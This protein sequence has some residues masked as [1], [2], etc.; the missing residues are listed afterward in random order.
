M[1]EIT[2]IEAG[3][4]EV[5][6]THA[7]MVLLSPTRV[8]KLKKPKN[9]GFFDYSTPTLRRHFCIE[10]VRVNRRLAPHVYLGVAPVLSFP[11]GHSS[12]GPTF[13][14]GEVP[15]P[16]AA[17][18]GG[19]VIDYAVVMIR[20]P[21]EATLES[22][23]YSRSITPAMLASV[24]RHIA[25]FHA[26]THTDEHIASFGSLE[27]VR[28]NWEENFEQ[29]EPYIGR[30]IDAD[31]YSLLANHI[32]HF[33]RDRAA[34]FGSRINEGRV[35]DCH[36]D[37]RLQHVYILDEYR[38]GELSELPPMAV[39]DGIEFNERF[40]Y[41]DVACEI[42]F[43]TME[44]D[45]FGRPDL[46][47]A[48][49]ESYIAETG[50]HGLLELLPFYSCYRACVRGK[51]LGFQL[52]EQ[53]VPEEQRQHAGKQAAAFFKLAASYLGG[54]TSPTLMLVGGLM[55]TGKTTLAL[56]LRRELGWTLL[57]S[58][59]VR[60]SLAHVDP[61]Q[62]M[63]DAFE[64]GLYSKEWTARTYSALI[65]KASSALAGGH[66]VVLD[67]SF[68]RYTDRQ[69]SARLAQMTVPNG[70]NVIF[71]ECTCPRELALRRLAKRW[72]SR[73]THEH[74]L[75]SLLSE[76]SRASGVAGMAFKQHHC[77]KGELETALLTSDGR[78]DLYDAQCAA[79]QAF[80]P[81]Q[82]AGVT[83]IVIDTALPLAVNIEQVLEE[84]HIPHRACWL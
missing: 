25:A 30:T 69:A 51:V 60:K 81:A 73:I 52:D 2:N 56:T 78:P 77:Q 61:A 49:V 40:R 65:D 19:K 84:L 33:M 43:L 76:A 22:R 62:P 50:D 28:G 1:K 75:A 53:E 11:G 4:F 45:A 80:D 63:A 82:E 48:F 17:L 32:R 21:D 20:L 35:R 67:A 14:P 79:W 41:S 34:L 71:L 31:T 24:A 15:L 83:H 42:A 9:F 59:A 6:Q 46:S 47:R 44:L 5:I 39:L 64:Q 38:T 12:F 13:Q 57:S 26:S 54:S 55:G 74:F 29:M 8:Y 18:N 10:E 68:V 58:D 7:S 36:G 72:K 16:G 37:L 23:I 70:V 66:S 27:V 3:D